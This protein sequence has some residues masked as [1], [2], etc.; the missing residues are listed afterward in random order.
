MGNVVARFWEQSYST[1]GLTVDGY[2]AETKIS[3][4]QFHT[5]FFFF[6][7]WHLHFPQ[8]TLATE[9]HHWW[10]SK[11]L[12][13]WSTTC[14]KKK[15]KTQWKMWISDSGRSGWRPQMSFLLLLCHLLSHEA[16]TYCISA[17]CYS[18]YLF[19][20]GLAPQ[21]QDLYGKVDFTGKSVNTS[22]CIWFPHLSLSAQSCYLKSR[23]LQT[24]PCCE[25]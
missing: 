25:S 2:T 1:T 6:N 19:K 20:L 4:F 18:L 7:T 13:L 11:S 9:W 22:L 5:F 10:L 23:V 8:C 12:V 15:K 3:P 24:S 17:C 14:K 16:F 21:I